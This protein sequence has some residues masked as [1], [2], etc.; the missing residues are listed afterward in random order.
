MNENKG[1]L[2]ESGTNEFEIVEFTV[3]NVA[4]GVNVAKVREIIK[5]VPA[6]KIVGSHPWVDGLF[7]LRNRSIPLVCLGK[8]LENKP[9]D[10]PDHKIIVCEINNVYTG[11]K[12][13]DV[14]RIHR[15]SWTQMEPPPLV[16]DSMLTVGIVKFPDRLIVLLDFEKI[17]SEVYPEMNKKLS[18]Q[19]T[20]EDLVAKRRQK[21]ILIAE[22]SL[23]LREALRNTLEQAGYR[24]TVT[25]DGQEAWD[26][27]EQMAKSGQ[28]VIDKVQMVITDIEMPR[29]D[30][31]H[32][33]KRIKN[34]DRLKELPVAI[35]SS[36]ISEE[37]RR[38]GE[39]LG[40]F[41]QITKPEI[42]ELIGIVDKQLL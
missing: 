40:A 36:L 25:K 22:D 35:F 8:C 32:L 39:K 13:E 4:Y 7:V 1:I 10:N 15:V 27:L 21:T 42:G 33:L 9:I 12:V 41:A 2:L 11:F 24:L 18:A 5:A 3:G 19:P 31:H 26:K 20:S 16:A 14:A 29:M 6:T 38:K 28:P 30:G 34:D 17:L 37:M 23:M